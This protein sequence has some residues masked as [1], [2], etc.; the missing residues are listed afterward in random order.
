MA[1]KTL[2]LPLF[3]DTY[4]SYSINLEGNKYILEFLFLERPNTWFLTLKDS[5]Q[6][7]LVRNQR[8]TPNTPLFFDYKI[9]ELTG[10]FYFTTKSGEDP[11]Y[12]T[13]SIKALSKLFVLY[14][15]YDDGE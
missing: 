5:T 12:I 7:T 11:E 3:D 15:L 2:K 10:H 14:Y 1:I 13:G 4:Y 8:L 6:N 9:P